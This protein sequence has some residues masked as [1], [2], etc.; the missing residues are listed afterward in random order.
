[1]DGRRLGDNATFAL[2]IDEV[3]VLVVMVVLLLLV[4][5]ALK[6]LGR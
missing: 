3:E 6:W 5:V 2:T 1:M 4:A